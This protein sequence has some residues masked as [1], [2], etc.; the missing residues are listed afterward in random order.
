[1]DDRFYILNPL[2]FNVFQMAFMMLELEVRQDSILAK[3]G[4]IDL[5]HIE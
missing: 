5:P 1:M 4:N 3:Q 2:S